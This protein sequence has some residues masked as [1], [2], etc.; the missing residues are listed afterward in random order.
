MALLNDLNQ[1][2]G[3]DL[4][5]SPSG[6]LST[7]SGDLRTQQRII[8]R[9]MTC[10]ADPVNNLPPDYIWHPTYG[11]GL[12][13]FI[14]SDASNDEIAAVVRGQM[15][16]EASVAQSPAPTVTVQA[17]TNGLSLTLTYTDAVSGQPQVLSFSATN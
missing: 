11:A 2:W 7:A 6:D 10:P 4:S 9:L 12:P 13:R 14:G 5:A 15:M 17:I 16:M 3:G 1:N 8:R